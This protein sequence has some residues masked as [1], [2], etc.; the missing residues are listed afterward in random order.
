MRV[1]QVENWLILLFLAFLMLLCAC[2]TDHSPATADSVTEET[3][4]L[5]VPT[6]LD[7]K[8][9]VILLYHHITEDV[10]SNSVSVTRFEEHIRALSQEGYT[11][12]SFSQ[13]IDFV[14]YGASLPE[15]PVVITFD[16]GYESNLT[17]AAPILRKYGMNA[18]IFVIGVSVGKDTY[19]DT[20]VSMIPHFALEESLEWSD[21][22][23]IESHGYDVHEVRGRDEEPIRRGVLP[24]E[25]ESEDAYIS[26][27]MNDCEMMADLFQESFGREPSVFAYPTGRYWDLSEKILKDQGFQVTLTTAPHSNWLIPGD[28]SCLYLMGRYS[29]SEE[30]DAEQLIYILT[31]AS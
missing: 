3:S 8:E 1:R 10:A 25:G 18:T 19:K 23:W 24:R 13:V 11:A 9:I 5:T 16:D 12:V 27:L 4:F 22:I 17:L 28:A 20:G 29:M 14:R 26:F 21:V 31:N 30:I 6:N 2:G 7:P 15:K